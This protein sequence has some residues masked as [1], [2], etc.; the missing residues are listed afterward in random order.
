MKDNDGEMHM[1]QPSKRGGWTIPFTSLFFCYVSY[2]LW[3]V[4]IEWINFIP[5]I[6]F[7]INLPFG[8]AEICSI[9]VIFGLWL[10]IRKFISFDKKIRIEVILGVLLILGVGYAFSVYPDGAFDTYNYHL[11][12]QNPQFENYF[13]EDFGYGNFQVWG[14]RLCDRMF[15]YFRMLFGFRLG[16]MLNAIALAISFEQV[17]FLLDFYDKSN[18]HRSP[19]H[20]ITN[21]ICNKMLWSLAIIFS[22]DAVMMLGTYYVDVITMPIGINILRQIIEKADDEISSKNIYTFAL[23]CGLWIGGKLTNVVYVFPCVFVFVILHV[24]N[25]RIKDW[26]I[27]IILGICCYAQYLIWNYKCTKNPFFPYYNTI[28]RSPYYPLCNFKDNRWGGRTLFEKVFWI[29][30]AVFKPEYRQCEIFDTHVFL[31]ALGLLSAIVLFVLTIVKALKKKKIDRKNSCLLCITIIA[32]LLW[33][34][35]TGYSRYFVIGRVYFGIIAFVIVN[36]ICHIKFSA[37]LC[38][39]MNMLCKALPGAVSAAV[40]VNTILTFNYSWTQGGW[41]WAQRNNETFAVQSKKVMADRG[42]DVIDDVDFFVLTSYSA[43]GIAELIAPDAYSFCTFYI[44]N[45]EEDGTKLLDEAL[46]KYSSGYDIHQRNFYDIENYVETLNNYQLYLKDIEEVIIP[47]GEEKFEL[48]SL[49]K[50]ES[51]ENTLWTSNYGSREIDTDGITGE[52]T[53]SFLAGFA[54]DWDIPDV[55]IVFVSGEDVISNIKVDSKDI[56]KYESKITIPENTK[57]LTIE[58]RY[59]DSGEILGTEEQDFCYAVNVKLISN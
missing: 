52:C 44:P 51:T 22:L 1:L 32:A 53:I 17:Y 9:F 5:K 23:L 37:R 50:A 13:E 58:A 33:G 24:K 20:F 12:A 28:F 2:M 48:L 49:E 7:E 26:I 41:G 36:L 39:L 19:K 15:F 8:I 16:T 38:A 43:Q 46:D 25:F 59:M 55:E 34:F 56:K 27:S 31:F 54:Y 21:V 11:I 42:F 14:F 30:Y 57:E 29:I 6:F 10:G 45:V 18:S 35:T 4:A 3:I 40:I 47:V